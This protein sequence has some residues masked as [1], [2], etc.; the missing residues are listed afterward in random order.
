MGVLKELE[1]VATDPQ[2]K[3]AER[4]RAL[5]L[6]GKHLGVFDGRGE[7]IEPVRIVEDV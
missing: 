3:A 2:G 4:L 5:E 7:K 6:L 1:K